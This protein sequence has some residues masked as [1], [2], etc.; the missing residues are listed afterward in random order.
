MK[1][2][3]QV[4]H[5]VG[6]TQ[7]Q[8]AQYLSVSYSLLAMYEKGLRSLPVPALQKLAELELSC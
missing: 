5:R 6:L 3:V 8:M 4:R 7:H 2:A 1:K